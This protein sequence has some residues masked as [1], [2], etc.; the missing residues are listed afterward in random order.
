MYSIEIIRALN[1][2]EAPKLTV[3][4]TMKLDRREVEKPVIGP[5]NWPFFC[6]ICKG[7]CKN[8]SKGGYK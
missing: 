4:A 1:K 3:G 6:P 2:P 8:N 5:K 7:V